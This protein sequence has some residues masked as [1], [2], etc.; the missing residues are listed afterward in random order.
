MLTNGDLV[1]IPQGTV[2]IN[3]KDETS[4]KIIT[5]PQFGIIIDSGLRDRSGHTNLAEE[6]V[7][8]LARDEV[9]HIDKRKLQLV[10]GR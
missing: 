3:N 4:L 8:V 7:K 5:E 1:R 2:A 10:G 6:V 9:L